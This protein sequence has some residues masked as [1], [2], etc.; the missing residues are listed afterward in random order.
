M[1]KPKI[2]VHFLSGELP[3]CGFS[4]E[5][6]AKWS[7]GNIWVEEDCVRDKRLNYCPKCVEE[8]E[9]RTKEKPKKN[10]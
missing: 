1:S 10:G 2:I 3:L 7:A 6:P 4:K 8:A 9:K 5:I